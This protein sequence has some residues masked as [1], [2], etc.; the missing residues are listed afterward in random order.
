MPIEKKKLDENKN[1][2]Y[3]SIAKALGLLIVVSFLL[4]AAFFTLGAYNHMYSKAIDARLLDT[5]P[6]E[7][8]IV[9]EEELNKYPALKEAID[10]QSYVKANPHEWSKTID[11]LDEKGSYVVK[12]EDEYYEIGFMTA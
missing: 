10:T 3:V 2:P 4:F 6:D 7:F 5:V 1:N 11:F 8:V 12:F 9:T